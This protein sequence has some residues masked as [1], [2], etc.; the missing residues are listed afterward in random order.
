MRKFGMGRRMMHF[1]CQ[2]GCTACCRVQG[3][4][5]L[6][7]EDVTR[8]AAYLGMPQRQFEARYLYRT[9]NLRRLRTPRNIRCAFLTDEGCSI[10]SV[11]PTQCRAF[12]FWPELVDDAKEWYRAS[13][14][15]PGIGKGELVQIDTA[16]AL[17]SEMRTAYPTIYR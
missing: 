6:T 12:P 7:E 11:K 10:H 2:P 4:V 13:R 5:Y 1:E 16:R 15:C 17:A 9:R 3:F 14:R 8:I